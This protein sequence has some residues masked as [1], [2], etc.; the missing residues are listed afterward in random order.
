MTDTPTLEHLLS[1]VYANQVLDGVKVYAKITGTCDLASARRLK[2]FSMAETHNNMD[3]FFDFAQ[4]ERDSDPH[5]SSLAVNDGN[6]TFT[7]CVTTM[8]WQPSVVGCTSSLP[9]AALTMHN[10]STS[11]I[12]TDLAR[13]FNL[14]EI[15][16]QPLG[17]MHS[18]LVPPTWPVNDLPVTDG[19][20]QHF[21][22]SHTP[23]IS[24]QVL[25]ATKMVGGGVNDTPA[26]AL[27]PTPEGNPSQYGRS[28]DK[29][30]PVTQDSDHNRPIP[31]SAVRISLPT[32]YAS[33]ATWKPASAKRKGP[34]SRIPLEARQILED[35]FAT[36]PYPCSWEMDIIAHQANL[37]VKKVIGST[38]PELGKKMKVCF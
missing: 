29:V 34:Q 31:H 27:S 7:E 21:E 36:N 1:L 4:L 33:S 8:D 14:A 23:S 16:N 18:N 17:L 22:P 11:D 15:L 26:L 35:E 25:G 5:Y 6:C 3:E 13:G 10:E 32:R 9:S 19:Y 37:D 2:T 30:V 38:I 20:Q 12:P 24:F 28:K